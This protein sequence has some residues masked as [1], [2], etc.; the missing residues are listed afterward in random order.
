MRFGWTLIPFLACA[1][2]AAGQQPPQETNLLAL[3]EGALPVVEAQFYGGWPVAGLLDD[4]ANSG[5]CC[6]DGKPTNNVFVFEMLTPDTD[7]TSTPAHNQ[8]LSEQRAG[9]VRDYLVGEGVAAERLTL[10]GLGQTKPVADNATE[11][12]RAQNRRV[13]LVRN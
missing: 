8:T 3:E 7:S 13:E 5:W 6:A 12:G 1:V 2:L 10:V 9:F 11:L 4:A